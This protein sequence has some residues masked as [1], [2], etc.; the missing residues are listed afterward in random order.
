[1]RVVLDDLR[2][3]LAAVALRV[4]ELLADLARSLA[5]PR[6]LA[7]REVPVGAPGTRACSRLRSWWQLVHSMPTT[8]WSSGPRMTGGS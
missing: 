8:P 6:H 1:M 3:R 5:D 4:L 7:R 2:E